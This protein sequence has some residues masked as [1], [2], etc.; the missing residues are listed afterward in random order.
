MSTTLRCVAYK[1]VCRRSLRGFA[2]MTFIVDGSRKF[3]LHGIGI[4]VHAN[5]AAWAALQSQAIIKNGQA[6][7]D[8]WAAAAGVQ[9]QG[10]APSV[11]RCR[12]SRSARP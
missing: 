1:R 11:E 7:K 5:G 10:R 4:H 6:V 9:Q 3:T 8:V 2:S 12:G